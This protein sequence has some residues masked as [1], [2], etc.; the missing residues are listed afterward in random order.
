MTSYNLLK[1]LHAVYTL[2]RG[3][4]V[5]LPSVSPGIFPTFICDQYVLKLKLQVKLDSNVCAQIFLREVE[6]KYLYLK[7]LV[8]GSKQLRI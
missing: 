1:Q 2:F 8:D 6:T 5:Y 7:F 3:P 4:E